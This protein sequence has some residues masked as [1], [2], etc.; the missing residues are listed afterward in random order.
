MTNLLIS[1]FDVGPLSWVQHEIDQA[2]TR[3]IEAL[4]S[5]RRPGSD[6]SALKDAR[7]H[8]HQAAGAIEMLGFDAVTD[9]TREI[10]RHLGRL[11][12]LAQ[13]ELELAS[14]PIERACRKLSIFLGE[15]ANGAPLVPLKLYPEYLALLQ[16]G[17]VEAATPIDLFYPDLSP[18]APTIAT[19]AT[20][21][22]H[23]L[24]SHL[25]KQRRL[26]QTGLLAWLRGDDDGART[27]RDA[28]VGIDEVTTHES[29]RSFWWTVCALFEAMAER[30]LE[31][32]FGLKQLVGRIDLQIRRVAEGS[33]RAAD[34]LRREVLYYVAVSRSTDPEVH[35]V[36][37]AFRLASLIP[38]AE[39]ITADPIGMRHLARE[40]CERLSGVKE[41]W[42]NFASGRAEDLDELKQTL[43]A[44]HATAAEMKH[45]ALSKLTAALVE[46]LD[47]MPARL[48]PEPLAME[49][50]TALLLAEMA[51]ENYA[52]LSPQ[53]PQQIDAMLS[54]LDAVG[55]GRAPPGGSAV[56]L[57]ELGR[58]AQERLLIAQVGREIQANLRHMEE[59]LDTFF[60]DNNKRAE[61]AAL[62]KDSS[63]IHGALR[64]LGLD[65]ADRLLA[66]CDQQIQVYANPG[67]EVLDDDLELLAESLC[68]LGFYMD[69]VEQQRSDCDRVIA[70]L[71]ARRLGEPPVQ[72]AQET[73]SVESAV[74]LLRADLPRLVEA[75]QGDTSDFGAR[76]NLKRKL[77]EL[78]DDAELIG[79]DH[80][81]LQAR[82][83]SAELDGGGRALAS[84]I[85]AIAKTAAS[86]P[87]ISGETQRLLDVDSTERDAAF[88]DVYLVE[89]SHTLAAI[90]EQHA[91][92]MCNAG[93]R[94][95][96]RTACRGFHTL[97]ESSRMVGLAELG[98]IASEVEKIHNL[99]LE[100][101]L[102]V[103]TAV[104]AM[105]DTAQG[106]FLGWIEA[107]SS[108]GRV[109]PDP[110]K[111]Y[112]ALRGVEDGLRDAMAAIAAPTIAQSSVTLND[113]IDRE[114]TVRTDSVAASEAHES[115]ETMAPVQP[116]HDKILAGVRDAV[117]GE[118]L[119]IFLEE[120][121]ELF[122]AA[123]G[124]LR[125][126]RGTPHDQHA[127][128]QLRRTLHTLKGSAR[129][130]G[131][132]R[133]GELTHAMESR[134][135]A[136]D[137]MAAATPELF[138]ALETDLDFIAYVLDRLLS[139]ETNVALPLLA[140]RSSVEAG[141]AGPA[142]PTYEL[143]KAHVD[144]RAMVVSLGAPVA[145]SR[146]APPPTPPNE[147][148]AAITAHPRANGHEV[149]ASAHAMPRERGAAIN[150][151]VNETGE[152]STVGPR[153]NGR[154]HAIKANLLEL[155]SSVTWLR[156]QVREMEIKAEAQIL[157]CMTPRRDHGG[158]DDRSDFDCFA[159][160]QDLTRSLTEA[161]NGVSTVQQ[162]LL[163][164]LDDV[165]LAAL[166]Q[167]Q[168]H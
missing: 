123:G 120:A 91:V 29:L 27:M 164:N 3:G 143:P 64:I 132:L 66:M 20:I 125:A 119:A 32:S 60:R 68:G 144:E 142:G 139:G 12:N 46:R 67:A 65:D 147:M 129:M 141:H 10:E 158:D 149:E 118:L 52:S 166:A 50:T 37:R 82:A 96:L 59:V 128:Q 121:A 24:P 138:E 8:V 110:G 152:V 117:D 85:D 134:L 21:T 28:I 61:L 47:R 157:P 56:T 62:A 6:V 140:P 113:R 112:A 51:F 26:Y 80:L 114:L 83:A 58:R 13:N 167:P 97:K 7:M 95:A 33:A 14:D 16:S 105:I 102:P 165:D 135:L 75:A 151:Q 5:F 104:V 101:E 145:R 1:E 2:L 127:P 98:E 160:F 22:A 111:L 81:A 126:W 73:E 79:D 106:S 155:T 84:G 39:V 99:L 90:G 70:P 76:D 54:R 154:L 77:A 19:R 25:A 69:A 122:P 107:L 9:L 17:G 71:L 115:I 42:L 49:F 86:A 93:D 53:F 137:D 161:L 156:N 162:S 168:E 72:A 148:A 41:A 92:L 36:Q 89:A 150:G 63:Q 146:T 15:L 48:I 108:A 130:A 116:I 87:E 18:R 88:L 78:K 133:L 23:K 30:G 40:A 11:E 109:A 131:A 4:A 124:Q 57:D 45:E 103:T 38:P 136:G 44:V 43:I 100:E 153:V 31:R 55:A 74:A 159:R 163:R 34:R 94:E 35:A